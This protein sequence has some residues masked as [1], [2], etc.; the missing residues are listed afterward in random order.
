MAGLFLGDFR[1]HFWGKDEGERL[2]PF[3]F[4]LLIITLIYCHFDGGD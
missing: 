1:Q 3:T 2:K 4:I